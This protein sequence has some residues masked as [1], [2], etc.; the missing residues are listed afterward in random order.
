MYVRLAFAVAAHLEPEI[1]VVDEVLAVGDADFQKKCLGK[2]GD[3]SNQGRTVLFVSHN[4]EAVLRLCT[5]AVFLL[6]GKIHAIGDAKTIVSKYLQGQSSFPRVVDLSERARPAQSTRRARFVKAFP[7]D[8]D[9]NWVLEFGRELSLD[10]EIDVLSSVTEVEIL[11]GIFTAAGFEIATWSN[12]CNNVRLSVRPG[13]NIFRIR[14][15][16]LR[17]LPG[18]YF[19]G[20]ALVS[21]RGFEEYAE[22]AA[23]FKVV[24]SPEAAKIHATI[25]R[26]AMVASATVSLIG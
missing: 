13:R 12:R 9:D 6:S 14:F 8:P 7:S 23:F 16:Q 22:P 19:L 20:M 15:Q 2:I 24:S 1:L 26:G 11:V 17:L 10:L 5:R 3:V 4:M 25:L 18:S 21:D